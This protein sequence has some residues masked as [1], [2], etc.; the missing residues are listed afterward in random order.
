[1]K[2]GLYLF[3]I[4]LS[5]AP[6]FI[7]TLINQI[8]GSDVELFNLKERRPGAEKSLYFWSYSPVCGVE[9]NN[10]LKVI[11]VTGKACVKHHPV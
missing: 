4:H 1:M 7:T 9:K 11:M 2:R 5:P 3:Y 8:V 10:A 6:M